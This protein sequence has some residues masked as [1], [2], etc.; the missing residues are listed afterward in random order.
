MAV[1][2][3]GFGCKRHITLRSDTTGFD[4]ERRRH[5]LSTVVLCPF[6]HQV[7]RDAAVEEKR[8]LP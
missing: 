3:F 7:Q 8:Y 6:Q 1:L 5:D 2:L 4:P